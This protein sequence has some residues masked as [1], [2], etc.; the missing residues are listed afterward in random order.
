ME[1]RVSFHISTIA[2]KILKHEIGIVG[3]TPS[4]RVRGIVALTA[5]ARRN[6]SSPV[7]LFD[8]TNLTGCRI[9]A[10]ALPVLFRGLGRLTKT[11]PQHIPLVSAKPA[12]GVMHGGIEQWRGVAM[13]FPQ[14]RQSCIDRTIDRLGQHAR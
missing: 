9:S 11:G 6:L 8:R 7:F 1:D 2:T 5:C 4:N 14:R 13:G 3:S 10:A 12:E